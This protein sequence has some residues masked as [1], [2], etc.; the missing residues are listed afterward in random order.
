MIGS[1]GKPIDESGFGGR[2]AMASGP[3]HGFDSM[4]EIEEWEYNN[5]NIF[6]NMDPAFIARRQRYFEQKQKKELCE[7]F[8]RVVVP[9]C[10]VVAAGIAWWASRQVTVH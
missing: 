1:D 10:I 9:A 2:M 6:H 5:S 8:T 4:Q 7:L 3:I